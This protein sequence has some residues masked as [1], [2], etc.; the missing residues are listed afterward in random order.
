M[1]FKDYRLDER[2][3]EALDKLGYNEATEVQ[4]SVLPAL[5]EKQDLIVQA[6]TGSGKTAAF[7]IPLIEQIDWAENKPQVLVLTPTR[8]LALQIKEDFDNIGTYKKIKTLAVFGKQPYKFQI[9]DLKQKTHV[10]VGTPGRVLDHLERETMDVSKLQYLILDEAD[11]MLNMGFIET[12]QEILQRL[13]KHHTTCLFS[14]TM[15]E[16]IV[17]LARQFT[18][19]AKQIT[20]KEDAVVNEMIDAVAYEVKEHEKKEFLLK[21]LLTEMPTSAI[22]F[23]KTQEHVNEV[24]DY[25]YEQDLSV[26]KI[27]GGMLQEDRL[28]NMYDFR[29]GNIQF[30]VATDVAARGIDVENMT[31]VIN[32]D[33]PEEAER[34][35]HRIGRTAR[36]GKA[37]KAI[38]FLSQYDDNRKA[39]I[40]EYIH[41]SFQILDAGAI[42]NCAIKKEKIHELKDKMIQKEKKNKEIQ[43]DI[44]RLYLNGGKKKKIRPGDI[45]GAICEIPGVC[46]DDIG[47]IQVQEMGSYVDI[48]NNKGK[49]VLEALRKTTIKGKVLKVQISKK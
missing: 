27:H 6:K 3:I 4:K 10:V 23:C 38:S 31:H 39:M 18:K 2:I 43:K 19:D 25:L 5:L 1:N 30:L 40:E 41:T 35:I 11:E 17:A 33:L 44:L 12:V 21:L 24:C 20:I 9:H 36:I 48:L 28:D 37:G 34:Y 22:I 32:Y 7:A 47:I 8:E 42:T 29:L 26:D 16:A 49:L 46:A 15:P 45:V 14:A 13:P